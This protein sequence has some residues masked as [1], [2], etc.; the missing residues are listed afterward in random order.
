M[1]IAMRFVILLL[2]FVSTSS[3]F[4]RQSEPEK[5]FDRA[6]E[7]QKRGDEQTAIQNYQQLLKLRPDMPEIRANLGVALAKEGRFDEAIQQYKVALTAMPGNAAI[8]KNLGLAYFKKK[9]FANARV[10]FQ[11]AHESDPANPQ[12]ATLYGDCEV[13]LGQASKA[14]AMLLSMEPQNVDNY[15]FEY[16]LGTAL[17]HTANRF[18]GVERLEKVAVATNNADSYFLAGSTLMDLH[19]F[20][21]ARKDLEAAL[22]LNPRLPRIYALT[23]MARDMTGDS[24]AAEPAFLEAVKRDPDDFDANL[25]LGAIL[26][27]QRHMVEAKSYLT[28]ALQ[29][30]PGSS[31]AVYQMAMW[32]NMS[33][34]Y[35]DAAKDLELLVKENP[36]W[37]QPHI[38]LATVYYRLHRPADGAREREIVS[39]LTAQQQKQG[40]PQP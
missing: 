3:M 35:A 27:K 20:E 38:E 31:E 4:A 22:R 7:A 26:L 21:R 32:K 8:E 30:K 36:D 17:V 5:L 23:G 13:Q 29:L 9:D 33:G 11:K 19:E 15:D 37:L 10:A 6:V 12:I 34:E 39:K 40:P 2:A 18:D 14:A 1:L 25:Y 28:H 24:D 16:V